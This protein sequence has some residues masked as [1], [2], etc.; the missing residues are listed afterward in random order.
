MNPP[1]SR[2]GVRRD[3]KETVRAILDERELIAIQA[4]VAKLAD[5]LC[6]MDYLPAFLLGV[7]HAWVQEAP[8]G[9][10]DLLDAAKH[11]AVAMERCRMASLEFNQ[12]LAEIKER[13][14][15]AEEAARERIA[16]GSVPQINGPRSEREAKCSL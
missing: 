6:A 13:Q 9:R 8:G 10:R 12:R 5:S 4:I 2:E 7:Q 16:S 1:G 3:G 11:L 14:R 15:R